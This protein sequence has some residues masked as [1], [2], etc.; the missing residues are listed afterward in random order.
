MKQRF[1][2]L[3]GLSCFAVI[4][5]VGIFMMSCSSDDNSP[6]GPTMANVNTFMASLPAW[7][8]F[9]PPATDCDS[10]TGETIEDLDMA[11]GTFCRTTPCSITET[12]EQIVTYGT[13]SNILWLGGL[14][15]GNSY[16][17]GVG[18]ME[19][20][21]IRQR[22]PLTI[23]VNLLT[24]DSVSAVVQSPTAATVG[25]AI[26]NLV[27]TAVGHGYHGGSSIYFTQ[28]QMYSLKQGMLS[29]GLS[30]KY[31]GSE[32][33]NK[34]DITAVQ[35]KNTITAYFKQLMFETYIVQPQTPSAF[36]SDAFTQERLQEQVNLGYIGPTNLP[37]YVS[38]I[39]WGRIMLL[40]MSSDSSVLD[41]SNALKATHSAFSI[42]LNAK[43]QHIL[44]TAEMEVVTF[45]GDDANALAMIRSGNI[46][47]Y[48]TS[49]PDLTTA[50]P[51]A[52]ALNNLAD[53]SQAKV[54]ETTTYELKE[55][56]A[57]TTAYYTDWTQWRNAFTAIQDSCDN[58]F[59]AT[60][61]TNINKAEE[62]WGWNLGTNTHLATRTLTFTPENTGFDF[63]FYLHT[64]Q[65]NC[66]YPLTFNDDE[67]SASNMLSIG[68]ADDCQ[69]D[70]FE[71]GASDCRN[72]A[73]VFAIG[74]YV[75]D[76]GISDDEKLEAFYYDR[77]VA[78]ISSAQMPTGS[79]PVFM[80]VVSAI[81]ITRIVFTEGNDGDD[82]YI[83]DFC[84]GVAY[85]R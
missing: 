12:P 3:S 42:E 65:D 34:L 27:A 76:N 78:E 29:L 83:K 68:D 8:V 1:L 23:G 4:I 63:Q 45:G 24:G 36:F 21:P 44:Q 31:M 22:A 11:Q 10:A 70:S 80:G 75:G 25:Q 51:I 38:R 79:A 60:N 57:V 47:S 33:S 17:G 59:F 15:Q 18:S 20:L 46:S 61:A 37:V 28:K 30:A 9:C 40:T 67:F 41:M 56:T 81:P 54:G 2:L 53:N 52:Y 64:L 62:N 48:F 50:F 77:K 69:W 39:Q 66:P 82:I 74:T 14:I 7:D 35:R 13:F 84:F 19:E 16:A 49:S 73:Y 85:H 71:I 58:K 32:V 26:G 6:T 5:P 72:G 43:Y 55:C